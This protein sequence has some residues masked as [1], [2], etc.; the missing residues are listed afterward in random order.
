MTPKTYSEQTYLD[1]LVETGVTCNVWLGNGT[2]L[3]GVIIAAHSG[4]GDVLWLQRLTDQDDLSMVFFHNISTI[5]PVRSHGLGRRA[6]SEFKGASLSD[7]D[8]Q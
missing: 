2:K 6:A 1:H 8:S 5:A 4:G 3:T 7:N